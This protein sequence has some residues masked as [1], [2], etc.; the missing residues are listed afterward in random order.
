MAG[1]WW[2]K[3]FQST[4]LAAFEP[5]Y[6]SVRTKREILFLIRAL[7]LKKSANILDIPCGAGRHSIT[8][9]RLGFSRI[10]GVDQSTVLLAAARHRSYGL[11]APPIFLQGDM[12][13]FK[14]SDRYDAALIL[15]NSF[16]YFSDRN[17]KRVIK[18]VSRAL[19]PGGQLVL[20]LSNTVGMLRRLST[21]HKD[22]I[23]GGYIL[24]EETAFDR[25]LSRLHLRWTVV[26]NGKKHTY[27]G[28]FRLYTFPE[29]K[30]L[31]ES[32]NLKICRTYGSLTGAAYNINAPRL[33]VVARKAP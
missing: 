27:S 19:R 22:V 4:Y 31:L 21:E 18:N 13:T 7:R 11:T 15:G 28:L 32:E 1:T 17:N 29:T 10:T 2:K 12:R 33:V 8:L 5:L 9:A 24:T 3:V 20:D 30:Q 26:R 25:R 14:T 6:S 16:G 23:S